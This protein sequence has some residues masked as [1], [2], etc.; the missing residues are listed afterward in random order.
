MQNFVLP[1]GVNNWSE[2]EAAPNPLP[3]FP[4]A[5]VGG[6]A[7]GGCRRRGEGGPAL[8]SLELNVSWL[9]L[10]SSA[11]QLVCRAGWQASLCTPGW[12][13]GCAPASVLTSRSRAGYPESLGKSRLKYCQLLTCTPRVASRCFPL[14]ENAFLLGLLR[15]SI[16]GHFLG[17]FCSGQEV[18][19]NGE[20][21]ACPL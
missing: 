6:R 18:V 17:C 12:S 14:R 19:L 11:R 2:P 15:S 8:C 1:A 21:N 20:V 7:A 13:L 5:R 10:V 9:L 16:L 4:L 3:C